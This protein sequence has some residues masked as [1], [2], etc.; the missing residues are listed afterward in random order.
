MTMPEDWVLFEAAKRSGMKQ[1]P[2]WIKRCYDHHAVL[3]FR[4]LCNMIQKYEKP[5][6]DRKV[7]CAQE[8]MTEFFPP[9]ADP[10]GV[11]LRAIELWEEGFGK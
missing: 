8:A 2:D 6:V 9:H 11:A 1:C 4:A 5:P 3:A 10:E 7:L